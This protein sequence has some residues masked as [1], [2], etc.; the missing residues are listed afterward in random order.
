[1]KFELNFNTLLIAGGF[2]F[3][4]IY[5]DRCSPKMDNAVIDQQKAQIKVWE[6]SIL[7]TESRIIDLQ[8]RYKEDSIR[9]INDS[10]LAE[11]AYQKLLN[12]KS[13]TSQIKPKHEANRVNII[14]LDADESIRLLARRAAAIDSLR[15]H[16][17][18]GK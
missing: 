1:M 5:L 9:Y 17:G 8:I 3:M 14:S 6:D 10:I 13:N 2:I 12:A 4:F 11:A 7:A 16:R 15:L 18:K